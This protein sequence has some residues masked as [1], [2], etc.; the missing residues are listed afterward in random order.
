[1]LTGA[2]EPFLTRIHTSASA[3][4]VSAAVASC[5]LVP[6]RSIP[7]ST[8]TPGAALTGTTAIVNSLSCGGEQELG[9]QVE[10]ELLTSVRCPGDRR[11]PGQPGRDE[12]VDARPARLRA[13][14]PFLDLG[15]EC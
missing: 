6:A 15:R 11:R 12:H 14:G 3:W 7:A 4:T 5:V 9:R 2:A 13:A 1:M 10:C 8:A